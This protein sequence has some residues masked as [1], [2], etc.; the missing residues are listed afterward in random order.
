MAKVLVVRKPDRSIHQ[1]PISNKAKI[2]GY[3]N[4][5]PKR[6]QW[7]IEEMDED[8]AKKLPFIDSNYVTPAEAQGKLQEKD[9]KIKEL[10]A[11]LKA[12]SAKEPVETAT[13]KIARINAAKTAEE[14]TTILGTDDRKTVK[15][16]A[17]KM[18][19]SF[20]QE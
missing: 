16:A 12:L 17:D 7:Q 6:D 4:R 18:I 20:S 14:V 2:L 8:K 19:A 5:L 10:E 9:E 13:E 15:D 3:N 11:R 1:I